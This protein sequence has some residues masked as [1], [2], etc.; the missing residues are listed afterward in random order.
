MR[1]AGHHVGPEPALLLLDVPVWTALE[2]RFIERLVAASP[3][4]LATVPAGD[5]RTLER[6]RTQLPG[7]EVQS[8]DGLSTGA[9]ALAR[10]QDSLFSEGMNTPAERGEEVVFMSAPGESRECVEIARRIVREAEA[11]VPFDR[12]AVLLRGPTH[13]RAHLEEALRRARIPVHFSNGAVQ[14]DPAGRAFLA[15]LACLEDGLSARRFAE[16]LS[17]GETPGATALNQPPPPAPDTDRWVPP[18]EELLPAPLAEAA[19]GEDDQ[20]GPT[21]DDLPADGATGPAEPPA[22]LPAPAGTAVVAG[23]LRAPRRWEQILVDAAVIGGRARWERRLDGWRAELTLQLAEV[24]ADDP[25]GEAIQR[26]LDQLAALRA[27][28]LPILDDLEALPREASWGDWLDRL[29]ALATRTLRW[30]ERV[31][32]VL[33]ELM[34]MAPVGP[35][36]LREV[37]VVLARRLAN[38]TLSPSTRSAGRVFVGPV[39]TARGLAFDVVFV[40]GLAERMFP[41]RVNQDPLLRDEVRRALGADLA[42]IADRI[43][44]ERLAL[45]IAVGC[46]RAKVVLSYSRVDAEQARPRVPSFYGLEVLRAVEGRLPSFEALARTADRGGATRLGWPAP[47]D[48]ADAIDEAEHDLSLLARLVRPDAAAVTGA[49]RYLI[50]S[51]QHLARALRHRAMRWDPTRWSYADGL[52]LKG[53]EP[54]RAAL[55]THALSARS[56]S[57]T[58][59]QHFAAC[60]YRFVLHGIHKLAPREEPAAIEKIDP[61]NRGSL[62]HEILYELFTELRAA[63][64]VPVQPGNLAEVRQILERI[65]VAVGRAVQGAAGA[66]HRPGLGRRGGLHPRRPARVAPPGER[67]GA[68]EPL[69][70][71][72]RLRPARGRAG[73]TPRRQRSRSPSTAASSSAGAIDL[74]ETAADG[75]LRATDHKTGK[76]RQRPGSVVGGGESLQPVFYAL[77]LEKLFPGRPVEGGR[78]HYGTSAG[79]FKE[80]LVALDRRARASADQVAGALREALDR[81]FLPAAPKKDECRYLRLPPGLRTLGGGADPPQARPGRSHPAQDPAEPAMSASSNAP[82]PDAGARDRIRDDLA[83]T[84]IVIA[85]AGTGQDHRAGLPHRGPG[86]GRAGHAAGPG[87]RHLHR[88]GG[89]GDEAAPAHGDRARPLRAVRRRHPRAPR[90]DQALAELELAH[91]G[92]IHSLCGD[93]LRERPVEACVD[94]SFEIVAGD[95]QSGLYDQAFERWFQR[96][97]ADPPE[98]VRRILR[99]N[100]YDGPRA[101]LREAGWRLVELRGF[102]APWR[103][104]PLDRAAVIDAAVARLDELSDL[105]ARAVEPTDW[106]AQGI[107]TL[108]R[109]KEE[110]DRRERLRG[111]DHDGLEAELRDLASAY[112]TRAWTYRGRPRAEPFGAHLSRAEAIALRDGIKAELDAAGRPVR[113]RPGRLPAR[114]SAPA[115]GRIR[116]GQGGG[117]QAGLRRP[118]AARA[119]PHPRRAR[120]PPRAAGRFSHVLIDEFQDTDPLQAEILL[121]LAA[122]DPDERDWKRARPAPGK[123]F[124]V[125]DPKQSIYRFRHADLALYQGIADRL[126][127]A[128]AEVVHLSANFRSVPALQQ[129]VNGAFAAGHARRPGPHAGR[130]RPP[131]SRAAGHPRPARP[132]GAAHPRALQERVGRPGQQ[133]RHRAL[134]RRRHRRL[135][136]VAGRPERLEGPRLAGAAWCRSRPGTSACCSGACR[137]SATTPP[138]M[139]CARSRPGA[140]ARAGGRPGLRRARGGRGHAQRPV[141]HRV[142]GGRVLGLRHLARAAVLP[143][144]RAAAGLAP[145]PGQP[146]PLLTRPSPRPAARGGRRAP[147]RS[148]R[149]PARW[150]CWP[151]CT[152]AATGSPSP[153]RSCSCWRPPGPTPASP[154]GPTASRPWPTSC[155]SSTWP[156]AS[157]P[158]APAPS[159]ASSSACAIRPSATRRPTP[160][161][162]RTARRACAS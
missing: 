52:V 67:A 132:G 120:R 141:R 33:A 45:R 29:A 111:R 8:S 156:A 22:A 106:L 93:L 61:L 63:G 113:G 109:W 162:W 161:C 2:A 150:P 75:R 127:A 105:A 155:A 30:P 1:A 126:C 55:A 16:Y 98:G 71:G 107:A 86:A 85:A 41:Q 152:A 51:N 116:G 92:T 137:A 136:R 119:R 82:L 123:L 81:G 144:G 24:V 91:I 31:L 15:L 133:L 7:A 27:F 121:L 147:G 34:P 124:V 77:A 76:A 19:Q 95:A 151:G 49:A 59:M 48:P 142:A 79:E 13:Y 44:A 54:A 12:M 149:W 115:G 80:V 5:R 18:D 128:G 99:R 4:T 131:G 57:P 73:G 6:L 102:E 159:G 138:A 62:V 64:L 32:A 17:L 83:S 100:D 69:E 118:G 70:A 114:G 96:V 65:L 134:E 42:T 35:V 130:L 112:R 50:T 58:A 43:E 40:P 139:W 89:G 37:R 28:A 20:G 46:A 160:P 87:R 153:T 25:R 97:L 94:P 135:H 36:G 148:P 146:A 122:D 9:G 66:R 21:S 78:L 84:L 145:H 110:L 60:P 3:D 157:R 154:S 101:L 68:L 117:R 14:P 90:L 103:R 11:G 125:G 88:Q 10:L 129:A 53:D 72:A 26:D 47:D 158:P 39:A 74:V 104:D 56:Y 38:L 143:L 23:S 108:G 140:A